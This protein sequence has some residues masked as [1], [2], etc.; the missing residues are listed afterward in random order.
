MCCD[1]HRDGESG[2]DR[3]KYPLSSHGEPGML[4]SQCRSPRSGAP[5]LTGSWTRLAPPLSSL[6]SSP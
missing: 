4:H 1:T 5:G 6:D 2:F 3:F